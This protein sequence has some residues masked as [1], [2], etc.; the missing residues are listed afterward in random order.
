[1]E[2]DP[3]TVA[4]RLLRG[5]TAGDILLLHDGSA[6]PTLAART[7]GRPAVLE[8]LPAVLDALAARGLRAV[9]FEPVGKVPRQGRLGRP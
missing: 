9:P 1:M 7:A 4:R 6:A 3:G 2:R 8:A 5:L